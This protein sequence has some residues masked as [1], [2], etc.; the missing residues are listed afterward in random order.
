MNDFDIFFPTHF[1]YYQNGDISTRNSMGFSKALLSPMWFPM[2][3][4]VYP[5]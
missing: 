4:R 2:I 5:L 1:P 3:Q